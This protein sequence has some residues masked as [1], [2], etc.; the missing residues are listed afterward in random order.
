VL[1]L[2]E[3]GYAVPDSILPTIRAY[4]AEGMNFAALRLAPNAGVQQMQ[5]VRVTT[6]GLNLVF[7]LRMVAAGVV[8]SVNLELYIFAEGRYGA[9]NFPTVEVLRDNIAF[10]WNT[11]SYDYDARFFAAI[12]RG[13]GRAWVVEYAGDVPAIVPGYT[14][15]DYESG[16]AV[17]HSA[18]DDYAVVRRGLPVPYVTKLR[19]RLPA[20]YLDQDVILEAQSGGPIGTIINVT[21]ELNRPANPVCPPPPDCSHDSPFPWGSGGCAVST[22]PRRP[23]RAIDRTVPIA[24]FG[25][26]G[27][28]AIALGIV[29]RRRS[30][31]QR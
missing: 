16:T 8:D 10:D 27:V 9:H 21:R 30:G 17:T 1:W 15:T 31:S 14:T 22:A 25:L 12:A 6:P 26:G 29:R 11:R 19:T 3:H 13:G 23:R 4:V 24:L 2:Q 28:V 7:P 18:A 5:P 20:E